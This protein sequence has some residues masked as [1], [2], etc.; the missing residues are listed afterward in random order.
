MIL[1]DE[2]VSRCHCSVRY[3]NIKEMFVITDLSSTHGTYINGS[4]KLEP[5]VPKYI[6]SGTGFHVGS[7]KISFV[8]SKGGDM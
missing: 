2:K 1:S 5:N 6:K 3:D 8:V 4:V 7:E